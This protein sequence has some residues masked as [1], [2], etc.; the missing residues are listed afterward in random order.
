L[1]RSALAHAPLQIKQ[2]KRQAFTRVRDV[3][4]LM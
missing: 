2:N 4:R 3:R 1:K